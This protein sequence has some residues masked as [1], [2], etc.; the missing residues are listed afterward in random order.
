[1]IKETIEEDIKAEYRN[2][3]FLPE[4]YVTKETKPQWLIDAL[5]EQQS[6]EEL[7]EKIVKYKLKL[8]L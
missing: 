5:K 3:A 1:M 8:G 7:E 2:G 4:S 6:L